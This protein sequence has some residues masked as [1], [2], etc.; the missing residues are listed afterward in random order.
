MN[1]SIQTLPWS[2]SFPGVVLMADVSG[3]TKLTEELDKQGPAGLQKMCKILNEYFTKLVN[4][5]SEHGGDIVKFAGD[6]LVVVWHPKILGLPFKEAEDDD[7]VKTP[8]VST[9]WQKSKESKDTKSFRMDSPRATPNKKRNSVSDPETLQLAALEAVL[10]QKKPKPKHRKHN[11]WATNELSQA[12]KAKARERMLARDRRNSHVNEGVAGIGGKEGYVKTRK[13]RHDSGTIPWEDSY[14]TFHSEVLQKLLLA[15]VRAAVSILKTCSD[16]QA[17]DTVKLNLHMGMGCGQLTQMILGDPSTHLEHIV[18]GGPI[19]QMS[20]AECL[21]SIKELV[22]S[23]MVWELIRSFVLESDLKDVMTVNQKDQRLLSNLSRPFRVLKESFRFAPESVTIRK[24]SRFQPNEKEREEELLRHSGIICSDSDQSEMSPDDHHQSST[25]PTGPFQKY[26]RG[27]RSFANEFPEDPKKKEVE[28]W[29]LGENP[30]YRLLRLIKEKTDPHDKSLWAIQESN[31]DG[32]WIDKFVAV[33]VRDDLSDSVLYPPRRALFVSA[34]TLQSRELLSRRRSS[35]V[36]HL[37]LESIPIFGDESVYDGAKFAVR[38]LLEGAKS[39]LRQLKMPVLKK[40]L[41]HHVINCLQAETCRMEE[42]SHRFSSMRSVTIMFIKSVGVPLSDYAAKHKTTLHRAQLLMSLIQHC[43]QSWEGSVNKL[44]VDDKGVVVLAVFGLPSM[45]HPDDAARAVLAGLSI[46]MLFKENN[47]SCSIGVVS[48]R[49]FCGMVGAISRREYT[50]MGDAVNL[51]ARF[52]GIASDSR[53]RVINCCVDTYTQARPWVTFQRMPDVCVKGKAGMR[54]IYRALGVRSPGLAESIRGYEVKT[55]QGTDSPR[56]R[57]NRG[58]V[59][60]SERMRALASSREKR[61]RR[62]T[63]KLLPMSRASVT[64]PRN[65]GTEFE[66]KLEEKKAVAQM[67]GDIS[68]PQLRWNEKRWLSGYLERCI[69]E[70]RGLILITGGYG[71]GKS[72]MTSFLISNA[73]K[74]GCTTCTSKPFDMGLSSTHING[75]R[76]DADHLIAWKSVL[77]Q[78]LKIASESRSA[79]HNA[80]N[81]KIIEIG[82]AWIAEESSLSEQ[83]VGQSARKRSLSPTSRRQSDFS[84]SNVKQKRRASVGVTSISTPTN[85]SGAPNFGQI[86][87]KMMRKKGKESKNISNSRPLQ[88]FGRRRSKTKVESKKDNSFQLMRLYSSGTISSTRTSDHSTRILRAHRNITT[89]T[90]IASL[91]ARMAKREKGKPLLIV[92]DNCHLFDDNSWEVVGRLLLLKGIILCIV[93]RPDGQ[94]ISELKN[95]RSSLPFFS[96]KLEPLV[97]RDSWM[98]M[99]RLLKISG[100]QIRAFRNLFDVVMNLSSG[101]PLFIKFICYKMIEDE[102]LIRDVESGLYKTAKKFSQSDLIRVCLPRVMEDFMVLTMDNLTPL[103]QDI[104]KVLAA[105][106]EAVSTRD[107]A[108]GLGIETESEEEA[109]KVKILLEKSCAELQMAQILGVQFRSA[110][111][112]LTGGKRSLFD[113]PDAHRPE[114]HTLPG[115]LKA[116]SSVIRG[117]PPIALTRLLSNLKTVKYT[118]KKTQRAERRFSN[119]TKKRNSDAD[120]TSKAAAAARRAAANKIQAPIVIDTKNTNANSDGQGELSPSPKRWRVNKNLSPPKTRSRGRSTSNKKGK[121]RQSKIKVRR[122]EPK[123]KKEAKLSLKEKVLAQLKEKPKISEAQSNKND[124]LSRSTPVLSHLSAETETPFEKIQKPDIKSNVNKQKMK[125]RTKSPPKSEGMKGN[126]ARVSK[127]DDVKKQ[128]QVSATLAIPKN[129]RRPSPLEGRCGGALRAH[130]ERQREARRRSALGV[131]GT[132]AFGRRYSIDQRRKKSRDKNK[133]KSSPKT[134]KEDNSKQVNKKYSKRK[135]I[136]PVRKTSKGLRGK[137]SSPRGKQSPA[138]GFSNPSKLSPRGRASKGNLKTNLPFKSNTKSVCSIENDKRIGDALDVNCAENN[139]VKDLGIA[140][141][142][143]DSLTGLRSETGEKKIGS[144]PKMPENVDK[145]LNLLEKRRTL[146]SSPD[147][148]L[149]E[150]LVVSERGS[151]TK[152][153]GEAL[154]KMLMEHQ[155]LSIAENDDKRLKGDEKVVEPD[156]LRW[157]HEAKKKIWSEPENLVRP[158]FKESKRNKIHN[159]WHRCYFLKSQSLQIVVNKMSLE[160]EKSLIRARLQRMGGKN[161]MDVKEGASEPSAER[162]LSG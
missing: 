42:N 41:P 96:L 22:V 124:S 47:L 31:S 44:M 154:Q 110:R 17:T 25:R 123:M 97:Y 14:V 52:M 86:F 105:V 65:I 100:E 72:E 74:L 70:D 57:M 150:T 49:V 34:N 15:A 126:K 12:L 85:K 33:K 37:L 149:Y 46:S 125:K 113:D 19:Q 18:C 159:M 68:V 5:I 91:A 127:F 137:S 157:R 146:D 114:Y 94:L 55:Q 115:R 27:K 29:F 130:Y 53:E 156:A 131:G 119:M 13:K 9:N 120:P 98:L 88:R 24:P 39:A 101:S 16:F 7:I 116:S 145:I 104:V 10:S 92:L 71:M 61:S 122:K 11:T 45:R 107:I 36:N 54:R 73:T 99:R 30:K 83:L 141:D 78:L 77:S 135:Q 4:I 90:A 35:G 59:W 21:S 84:E 60:E 6:A 160:R 138:S 76:S 112:I 62:H 108:K 23:P 58:S 50:T 142:R 81:R 151:S 128:R 161:T 38:M 102:I 89:I 155:R 20:H 79:E 95:L 118:L 148:T 2:E 82:R 32:T 139:G 26:V 80:L 136:S 144:V 28:C 143:E 63:R 129:R 134:K 109:E 56:S 132:A 69:K 51:S 117:P 3:F 67:F 152:K 140:V 87:K 106:E 64:S 133:R 162:R 153:A 121:R 147:G 103:Q 48:G 1:N 43:V 8:K 111:V 66:R 93:M 75:N 40:F 158:D